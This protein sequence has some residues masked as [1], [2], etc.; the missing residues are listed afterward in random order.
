M[1]SNLLFAA[2]FRT[3]EII[4]EFTFESIIHQKSKSY[5]VLLETINFAGINFGELIKNELIINS[6]VARRF[7]E[8]SYAPMALPIETEINKDLYS[9]FKD[10]SKPPIFYWLDDQ[11]PQFAF[12]LQDSLF[13]FVLLPIYD[14]AKFVKLLRDLKLA[15]F[16]RR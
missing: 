15:Y 14:K 4:D 10:M 1:T 11:S 6:Y 8:C 9:I 7:L 12:N 13:G 2:C 5:F 3:L 16:S